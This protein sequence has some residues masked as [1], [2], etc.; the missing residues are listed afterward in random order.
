MTQL[1][2]DQPVASRIPLVEENSQTAHPACVCVPQTL[3]N[4]S[5]V[6]TGKQKRRR[7]S[8][9]TVMMVWWLRTEHHCA[10]TP[11]RARCRTCVEDAEGWT[12]TA[13]PLWE[14][15]APTFLNRP[16]TDPFLEIFWARPAAIMPS[17]RNGL[18]WLQGLAKGEQCHVDDYR[19]YDGIFH[20]T[21]QCLRH[22]PK[23]PRRC[24]FQGQPY[25][26]AG[27]RPQNLSAAVPKDRTSMRNP[28]DLAELS[29]KGRGGRQVSGSS[30]CACSS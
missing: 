2:P 19:K 20:V 26:D 29:V 1:S 5:R 7:V 24:Q 3:P 30:A 12:G 11:T 6:N 13:G 16:S 9:P 21:R 4:S 14:G 22:W 27:H 25:G 10:C 18:R 15:L 28:D 17:S 8:A 23:G